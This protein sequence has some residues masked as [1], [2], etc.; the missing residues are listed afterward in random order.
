MNRITGMIVGSLVVCAAAVGQAQVI[1]TYRPSV[2]TYYPATGSTAPAVYQ[3]TYVA[4]TGYYPQNYYAAAPITTVG[5]PQVVSTVG[6]GGYGVS[7]VAAAQPYYGAPIAGNACGCVP[8]TTCYPVNQISYAQPAVPVQYAS[9]GA[10]LP[11]NRY[12]GTNLFGS[13][14]VYANGQPLRNVLRWLGP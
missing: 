12:I 2:V 4:Q 13:P 9:G 6:Y 1:G 7:P 11:D 10:G 3:P 5:G 14:K 8:Q